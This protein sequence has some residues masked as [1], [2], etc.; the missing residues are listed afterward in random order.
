MRDDDNPQLPSCATTPTSF[1]LP[2]FACLASLY[3]VALPL[4]SFV[5]LGGGEGDDVASLAYAA[6]P[7]DVLPDRA[8]PSISHFIATPSAS[9]GMGF[10]TSPIV[11]SF[12]Y[13]WW[14]RRQEL[15]PVA[16][17]G[18]VLLTF[19]WGAF[20]MAP[21]IFVPRFHFICVR[22]FGIGEIQFSFA[23]AYV[24]GTNRA[25]KLCF[26]LSTL[27]FVA[28]I[29]LAAMRRPYILFEYSG[30]LTVFWIPT[31]LQRTTRC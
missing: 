1:V 18:L 29:V 11:L 9:G 6:L 5:D 19:G 14:V 28:V 15:P 26:A 20:L 24:V 8:V 27:S 2:L 21:V 3:I 31:L 10:F 22:G 23:Y 17:A 12:W 7:S 30:L 13:I 25:A 4:L 16:T